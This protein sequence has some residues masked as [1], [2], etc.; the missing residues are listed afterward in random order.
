MFTNDVPPKFVRGEMPRGWHQLSGEGM[1]RREVSA[2]HLVGKTWG[3]KIH[4]RLVKKQ[5][6]RLARER[7]SMSRGSDTTGDSSDRARLGENEFY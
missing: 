6:S 5:T 2:E 1:G 3:Q 7:N 4:H